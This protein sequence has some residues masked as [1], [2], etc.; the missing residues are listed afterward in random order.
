MPQSLGG[1][2]QHVLQNATAFPLKYRQSAP[3]AAW[4]TL[5]PY[6]ADGFARPFTLDGAANELELR[7]DATGANGSYSYEVGRETRISIAQ[8]LLFVAKLAGAERWTVPP[9]TS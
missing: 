2:P 4:L 1:E 6:T 9:K 5:H 8:H 3:R 7:D